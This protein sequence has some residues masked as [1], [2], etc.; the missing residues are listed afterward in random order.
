MED[1]TSGALLH[2]ARTQAHLSQAELA[3]RAGVAQSVISAYESDRREPALS[4]LTKLISATGHRLSL[5]LIPTTTSYLGLPNTP[6]GRRLRQCRR[7]ILHTAAQH[8]AHN[9][10]VFGSVSRGEETE[11]SDVDLLID[12]DSEMGL[13]TLNALSRKLTELIG[14]QAD[15][16]PADA[17]KPYLRDQILREAITL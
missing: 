17:L 5:E 14:A 6:M 10:R 16:I 8:G 4:T 7:A 3:R 9:L 11:T 15:V 2:Q 1:P 13:I 12:F